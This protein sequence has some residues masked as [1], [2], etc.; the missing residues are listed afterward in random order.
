MA[1]LASA[2]RSMVLTFV[3]AEEGRLKLVA[4]MGLS[5]ERNLMVA[6][7]GRWLGLYQPAL[8]RSHPFRLARTQEGQMAL[9]IDEASGLVADDAADA[10]PFFDEAGTVHADTQKMADFLTALQASEVAA[11]KATDLLNK[12]GLIEA[13]P[14][15]LGQ[16]ASAQQVGGLHRI[17]ESALNAVTKE[18]LPE[19]HAGG[20][21]AVAYAQLISM[22]NM[23][24]LAALVA[25]QAKSVAKTPPPQKPA[26]T[27]FLSDDDGSLKIDWAAILKN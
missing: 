19:L 17:K 6:P 22:G 13:W 20:A 11:Q 12:H 1:E 15:A 23:Q 27:S 3:R 25:A 26:D 2:A 9:C 14:L 18:A 10:V 16:G 7:G 4:L 8:L 24:V 5:P 21:L